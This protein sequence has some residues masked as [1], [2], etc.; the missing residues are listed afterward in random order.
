[1][2][3]G[4]GMITEEQ[5][6]GE[7]VRTLLLGTVSTADRTIISVISDFSETGARLRIPGD[8]PLPDTFDL[9][10]PQHWASYQVALRWRKG[11]EVGVD[12]RDQ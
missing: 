4:A 10:M 8:V 3:C 7:R 5:R 11:D 2:L 6:A 1:M 12:F 9:Y